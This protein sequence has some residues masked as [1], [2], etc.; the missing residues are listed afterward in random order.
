[1]TARNLLA[2]GA[3]LLTLT[4]WPASRAHANQLNVYT[5]NL[6]Q[7]L[8][9]PENSFEHSFNIV[10]T[11]ASHGGKM[12]TYK[13]KDYTIN[14]LANDQWLAL[15]WTQNG[16]IIAQGLSAISSAVQNRAFIIYDPANP[17]NQLS[18]DCTLK[19]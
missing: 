8:D 15:A 10:Q 19:K 18:I 1:M 6:I 4:I 16:K 14:F 5:C 17:E 13:F 11:N 7:A 3:A 9:K 2:A 12:Y